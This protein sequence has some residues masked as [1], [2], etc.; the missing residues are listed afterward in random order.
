VV[1]AVIAAFLGALAWGILKTYETTKAPPS[2]SWTHPLAQMKVWDLHRPSQCKD[3]N[4][5]KEEIRKIPK[6]HILFLDIQPKK[7]QWIV[8]CNPGSSGEFFQRWQEGLSL[9]DLLTTL[10]SG[11]Y[12]IFNVQAS[13]KPESED[14]LKLLSGFE[15]S[16]RVGVISPSRM[17]LEEIRKE[18]P[19]W[20]FGA[21]RTSLTKVQT[22]RALYLV[23]LAPLWADFYVITP[24]DTLN[25]EPRTLEF[26][27]EQGKVLIKEDAHLKSED[28]G[29][30]S[31]YRGILPLK[32]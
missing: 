11:P 10:Q 25:F 2:S 28:L 31:P 5:L 4:A 21:D 9:S 32:N 23:G 13:Q 19:Q 22:L 17:P 1:I 7:E 18:R 3:I 24:E 29:K 26:L 20:F 15:K 30:D 8:F 27:K 16:E 6:D 14:L 12:V